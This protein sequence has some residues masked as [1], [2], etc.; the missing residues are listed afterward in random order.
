MI[1]ATAEPFQ[2]STTTVVQWE[3]LYRATGEGI[4]RHKH[5]AP[6]DMVHVDVKRFG[7]G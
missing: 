5:E 4:P 1:R 6:S 3:V 2:G 7:L